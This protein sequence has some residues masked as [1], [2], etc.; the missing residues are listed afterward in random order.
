[1]GAKLCSVKFC[2]YM[3]SKSADFLVGSCIVLIS[4]SAEVFSADFLKYMISECQFSEVCAYFFCVFLSNTR[5]YK[6]FP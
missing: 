5:T 3:I 4:K 1:M 2:K 6:T